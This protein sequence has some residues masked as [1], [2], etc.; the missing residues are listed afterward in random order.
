MVQGC[1]YAQFVTKQL[2]ETKLK[3]CK[4]QSHRLSS[5]SAINKTLT[6]GERLSLLLF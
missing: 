1:N 6:G 5:V 4:S 3:L 2:M